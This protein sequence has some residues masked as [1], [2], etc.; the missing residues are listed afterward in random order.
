MNWCS[1]VDEE[2]MG[3]FKGMNGVLDWAYERI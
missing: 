2:C 3:E 1:E